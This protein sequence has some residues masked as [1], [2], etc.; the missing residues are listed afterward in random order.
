MKSYKININIPLLALIGFFATWGEGM[1]KI[2]PK[3]SLVYPALMAVYMLLNG[4]SFLKRIS[5][6]QPVVPKEFKYLFVFIFIHSLIF[7]IL[8]YQSISFSTVA[9]V[10]VNEEGFLYTVEGKGITMCR[11]FLFMFFC[12]YLTAS[13]ANERLLKIFSTSYILGFICTIFGGAFHVYGGLIRIS[14]GLDDPNVMA[15][16]ALVA[17]FFSFYLFSRYNSKI[18]NIFI[19]FSVFVSL[20]AILM[21]FSRGA[22]LA[23]IVWLLFFLYKMG[24]KKYF[25]K[26]IFSLSILTSIAIISVKRMN[27]DIEL[28]LNRFSLETM[29][30]SKG[31]NRGMIWEAYLSNMDRYFVTGMGITNTTKAIKGNR[32]GVSE[33]YETH[34]IYITYFVEFG[35]F[36]LILFVLYW[37][38]VV[39]VFFRIDR[40][41]SYYYLV[42]LG[43]LF[44]LVNC[45]LSLD[46]GR[47]YW[48]VLACTNMVWS[49]Y[50]SFMLN[51]G[52]K[53]K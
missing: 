17:L 42:S 35:I 3:A 13:F 33:N 27:L 8:N 52:M 31:A 1:Q 34:N 11:Y 40:N 41:D 44:M 16:D 7:F 26:V 6:K 45:F 49:S 48:I 9:D 24:V 20:V 2:L 10:R 43:I 38:G 4:N 21:S 51:K 50:K 46:K 14:G 5:K 29:S 53:L 22:Y 37:R 15:F 30:E 12:V 25:W 32:Q 47:T 23:L 39:N 19:L 28:L 36:G 18:L